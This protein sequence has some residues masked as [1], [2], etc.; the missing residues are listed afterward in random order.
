MKSPSKQNSKIITNQRN[1]N[2]MPKPGKCWDE[3]Q[4]GMIWLTMK[5]KAAWTSTYVNIK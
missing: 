2:E 3:D 4:S 1:R 5:I